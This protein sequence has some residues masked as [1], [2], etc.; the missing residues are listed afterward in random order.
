MKNSNQPAK[1][2]D[3]ELDK[4][5]EQILIQ[6]SEMHSGPL[7]HPELLSKYN[8]VVSGAAERIFNMA[9]NEQRH[10]L[11]MDRKTTTNAIIMGYIGII[12]ALF[13]V[14]ILAGLVYYA[15][16]KGFDTTAGALGVGAIASVAGVFMFFKRS[17][18]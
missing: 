13:S 16:S 1:Y 14:L 6:K 11:Q 17:N 8:E 12:F 3:V 2:S 5:E 7:P 18:K 15:L 10:R 9:E 4:K